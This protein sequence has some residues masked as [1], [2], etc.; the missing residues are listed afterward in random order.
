MKKK[1]VKYRFGGSRCFGRPCGRMVDSSPQG[2][3]ADAIHGSLPK[4]T[5]RVTRLVNATPSFSVNAALTRSTQLVKRRAV[6]PL[7]SE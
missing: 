3:M 5:P 2:S 6:H 4:G 1:G 7:V